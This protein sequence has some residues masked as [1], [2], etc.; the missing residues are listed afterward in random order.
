MAALE[1]LDRFNKKIS[2]WLEWVGFAGILTIILVTTIDVAGSKL[3]LKPLFG[4]L[5]VVTLA[6]LIAASFTA[7][8]ALIAGRHVRVEFFTDL[9]PKRLRAIVDGIVYFLG[10]ALFVIIVWRLAVYAYYLQ[11]GGEVSGTARIALY[12][13]AYAA[14]LACV[15]VCLVYLSRLIQLCMRSTKE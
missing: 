4:S 7:A 9:M 5:D 1:S 2:E 6:Q 12:P 11:T 8:A 3:F 15:P 10:F 13:F 14:A